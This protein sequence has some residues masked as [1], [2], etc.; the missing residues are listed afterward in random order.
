MWGLATGLGGSLQSFQPFWTSKGGPHPL[1]PYLRTYQ[2]PRASR[3][4][5]H[6]STP[7]LQP[8]TPVSRPEESIYTAYRYRYIH[9]FTY[10]YIY[11]HIAPLLHDMVSSSRPVVYR[12]LL[13][14]AFGNPQ[15]SCLMCHAGGARTSL[16]RNQRNPKGSCISKYSLA[17]QLPKQ[18]V[19]VSRPL[20]AANVTSNPGS[21][22]MGNR[23]ARDCC[24][25]LVLRGV[26]IWERGNTDST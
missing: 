3:A 19:T 2:V 18:Q 25:R 11:A 15:T 1:T 17:A 7:P 13:H 20:Y 21:Y 26:L 5:R 6:P 8:Q 24:I 4:M 9:R 16:I 10:I 23:A 12:L 22:Y 14:G